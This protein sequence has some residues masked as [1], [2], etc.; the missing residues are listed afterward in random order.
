MSKAHEDG[1]VLAQA[2]RY[3][4]AL[5]CIRRCV[6]SEPDN[7]GAWNDM[8]AILFRL[9]RAKEAAGC[10]ERAKVLVRPSGQLYWN[11]AQSYLA[12]GRGCEAA[13]FFKDMQRMGVLNEDI[14]ERCADAFIRSG[15][16]AGAAGML[17]DVAGFFP[18]SGR[19]ESKLSAISPAATKLAFFCGADGTTFLKDILDFTAKRFDVRFFEG[20]TYGDMY[21]LMKWSDISWF[22]WCT[23]LAMNASKMP[24]VCRNIIRLHRYEAYLDCPKEV[25]WDNVDVLITVGNKCVNEILSRKVPDITSRTSIVEIAN[26]VD[27]RKFGFI[28][29]QRGPNIAFVGDLRLVKNPMFA[30]QCMHRLH[31][32][33][34]GYKIFFAGRVPPVDAFVEQY[35]RH[36]IGALGLQDVVFF[37]GWQEDINAWLADK[38]YIASMSVIESQGMGVLEAMACGLKPVVHNFPGAARILTPQFLFNTA[39]DFCRQILSDDYDSARYREFVEARYSLK[40]QLERVNRFLMDLG[41]RCR[42]QGGWVG[43]SVSAVY[44]VQSAGLRNGHLTANCSKSIQMAP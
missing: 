34:G 5:A 44:P 16:N 35:L 41:A 39:E 27:L 22:E 19:L 12:D 30:L 21:E 2:G 9:G 18:G 6:E 37:D 26:G 3:E 25:N 7:G 42:S 8:G 4:E 23:D 33:D 15:D 36:M 14:V 40:E 31:S 20:R 13:A 28:E 32:I 24:K 11:L 1:L 43:E 38:H 29:R 10:F 17:G